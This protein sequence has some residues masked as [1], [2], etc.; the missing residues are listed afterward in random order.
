MIKHLKTKNFRKLTD[1]T[2]T[3]GPGLQVIRGP[4]ER[5]K[6]T[7]IEALCYCL[8]GVKAC[9][10]SLAEVVT[11]GC[12]DKTLWVETLLTFE[13][14]DY[15]VTRSKSGA[16]VNYSGGRV[17]GQVE[18]TAFIERLLGAN[19]QAIGRLMLASQGEIRG[20]LAQGPKAPMEL[21]EKLANFD[22]IDTVIDLIQSN[23]VTG[24]TA[25]ADD[26]VAQAEIALQ[27]SISALVPVE[28]I[29]LQVGKLDSDAS[30]HQVEIDTNWGPKH[31]AA[32]AAVSE[33]QSQARDRLT[34]TGALTN[35]TSRQKLHQ[36]QR[37]DAVLV[38]SAV[39]D[40]PRMAEL[41][42]NINDATLAATL[43][44][45]FSQFANLVYP[46]VFWAGDASSLAT[47]IGAQD[48]VMAAAAV[49]TRKIEGLLATAAADLRV[50]E[51]QR[52][53][54][55]TCGFCNQDVSKFPEVAAKNAAIDAKKA[56][57]ESQAAALRVSLVE[58]KAGLL[59]AT[60]TKTALLAVHAS[61]VPF[62][63]FREANPS[64]VAVDPNFVPPKLAWAGPSVSSVVAD[65][66][67]LR[68]ELK[69]LEELKAEVAQAAAR[70][71]A[72]DQSLAEDL[73]EVARLDR[74]L[75][76][77]TLVDQIAA[78]QAA[79]AEVN[80]HY[81]YYVNRIAEVKYKKQTLEREHA[82]ATAA[83]NQALSGVKAL[84]GHLASAQADL[85]TLIFNN[86]LL[87]RVRLARPVIADRLWSVVLAAVSTFFSTMR[88]EKSVVTKEATGFKVNGQS[89][90][91][92]S[93][94]ALDC[95]G[96]ATRLALTRTFLT[97][98][99][100]VILDEP[101]AACD[102]ARTEQAL[103]FLVSVGFPQ[104]ILVTHEEASTGVAD[105]LIE[106]A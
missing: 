31:T 70:V 32:E 14:V 25:M 99:P 29:D 11:W 64:L 43:A 56:T 91:G 105:N 84:E 96:M 17:T 55:S 83:Y 89:I 97:S 86:N 72:L 77:L 44:A 68:A 20:A 102:T 19:M 63:R 9:R 90:T 106:I 37:R 87:K 60:E 82:V 36:E 47:E 15:T 49:Q 78:L 39:I 53:V 94:S 21:I 100:F 93:G 92:L 48:S 101:Y 104:T 23:R 71:T 24:S 67:A 38:A 81:D 18:V 26:R 61:A 79:L 3:F 62:E 74:E 76:A 51:S 85:K 1:H 28:P 2:F 34:L 73:A 57:T 4:N 52:V 65:P 10:D 88:G 40:E 98:A 30:V 95:L 58:V 12:A 27:S 103:G 35:A 46:A 33:A 54:G 50:L 45:K 80:Q 69:S 22:I 7:I 8:A 5:G 13:S 6:T 59:G 75:A 42:L 16:E 41:R 66:A